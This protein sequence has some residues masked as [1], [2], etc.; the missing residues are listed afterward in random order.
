MTVFYPVYVRRSDGTS[1]A[2][3]TASVKASQEPNEPTAEQ[4]DPKPDA[5][6]VSDFYRLCD[7]GHGKE[8]DWRRK[9][10]GMLVRELAS[11]TEVQGGRSEHL[12]PKLS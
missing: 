4:L 8:V 2:S 7:P 3:K 6:G 9:L 11:Q 1:Q 10:G 5:K 12:T